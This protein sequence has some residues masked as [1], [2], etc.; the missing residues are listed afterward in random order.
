MNKVRRI[1]KAL[2]L[3][4]NDIRA[5]TDEVKFKVY[6]EIDHLY[7]N[8]GKDIAIKEHKSGFPAITIDCGEIH[9]LT[10]IIS[11]EKYWSKRR[12]ERR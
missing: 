5:E 4:Y 12:K 9:V 2:R 6:D 11:L 10:D 7:Q 3:K 8:E 1:G